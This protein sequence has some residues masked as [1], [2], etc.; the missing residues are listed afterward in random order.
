VQ[1]FAFSLLLLAAAAVPVAAQQSAAD[2]VVLRLILDE[3]QARTRISSAFIQEGLLLSDPA[4]ADLVQATGSA[5]DWPVHFAARVQRDNGRSV[6][7][8]SAALRSPAGTTESP[9][10]RASAED[11]VAH[12]RARLR[13]LAEVIGGRT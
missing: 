6:V 13:A 2:S 11:A 3:D 7:T 1:A 4:S 10:P 8:L 9:A 12:M 5:L